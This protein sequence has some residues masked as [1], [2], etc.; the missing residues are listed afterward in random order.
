MDV[1]RIISR[2]TELKLKPANH[3]VFFFFLPFL[4]KDVSQW[5]KRKG[6]SCDNLR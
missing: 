5:L 6:L 2:D 1:Q 4:V 3:C